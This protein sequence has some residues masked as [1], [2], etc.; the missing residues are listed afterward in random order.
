MNIISEIK[1]AVYSVD[2]SARIILFGSY[3]RGD[4][5]SESDIDVLILLDKDHV[6][7][8]DEKIIKYPLY[9]I[10][11]EHGRINSPLVLAKNQ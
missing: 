7:R 10:E 6:S 8:Q 3:A 9:E 4:D 11:F 1:E 2:P 5:N